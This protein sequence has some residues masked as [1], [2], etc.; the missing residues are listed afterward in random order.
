MAGHSLELEL[1]PV[2]RANAPPTSGHA[3][4][5]ID[6]VTQLAI[7]YFGKPERA[8]EP[9]W[10]DEWRGQNMLPHL[11]AIDVQFAS[12]DPRA[13]APFIVELRLASRQG[14]RS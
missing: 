2:I 10:L 9:R 6:N 8:A 14:S 3:P 12:G 5:L 13:W 4:V 7:R 11:I 1:K